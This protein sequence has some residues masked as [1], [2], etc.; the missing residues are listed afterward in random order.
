MQSNVEI[1]EISGKLTVLS[2]NQFSDLAIK[3]IQPDTQRLLLDLSGLSFV[4][5][6]GL[7]G[8]VRLQKATGA[9]GIQMALCSLSAQLVQLLQLTCMDTVFEIFKDRE[10]FYHSWQQ[11]FPA[12]AI[13]PPLSDFPVTPLTVE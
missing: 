4:D 10:D 6:A 9:T 2:G 11:Q 12:D 3:Q 7:S 13:V 5:S 1:L 8:L